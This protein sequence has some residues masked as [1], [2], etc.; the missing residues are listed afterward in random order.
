MGMLDGRVAI[1]SGGGRGVGA[2][3]AKHMAAA[4]AKVSIDTRHREVE[5]LI[6]F[7]WLSG[8]RLSCRRPVMGTV[9]QAARVTAS[10]AR[11]RAA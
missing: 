2:E 8:I 10:V 7:I 9:A 6:E 3:I 4:G 11:A 5:K 1:V